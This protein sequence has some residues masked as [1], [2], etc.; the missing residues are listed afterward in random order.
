[1][2]AKMTTIQLKRTHSFTHRSTHNHASEARQH[3]GAGVNLSQKGSRL[4]PGASEVPPRVR[5]SRRRRRKVCVETLLG[6][7]PGLRHVLIHHAGRSLQ[8]KIKVGLARCCCLRQGWAEVG[9]QMGREVR[10]STKKRHRK[11]LEPSAN[12]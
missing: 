2:A 6:Y 12:C 4:T 9:R 1:M 10:S 5:R 11:D 8:V 3:N 7:N